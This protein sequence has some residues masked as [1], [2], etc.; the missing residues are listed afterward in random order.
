M[1]KKRIFVSATSRDLG[2]DRELASKAMLKYGPDHPE[3]AA[4][5]NNLAEL[6]QDT[7]RLG[8][9]EPLSRRAVQIL[10]EFR[11]RTGHEHPNFRV[12]Q[13]N[14]VGLLEALGRTPDEIEQQLHELIR[15]PRS[16]HP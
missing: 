15:P 9:A 11:R 3:V 8:E 6:L 5:L 13:A 10:I 7:N 14:Y 1:S 4:A 2:S 12:G 16:E